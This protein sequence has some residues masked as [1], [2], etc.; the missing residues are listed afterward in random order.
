MTISFP[1]LKDINCCHDWD[2]NSSIYNVTPLF[3]SSLIFHQSPS[4]YD[5]QTFDH[6]GLLPIPGMYHPHS[7]LRAFA[8]SVLS[9]HFFLLPKLTQLIPTP[10]DFNSLITVLGI[11]SQ[12]QKPGSGPSF[13][14]YYS[15]LFLSFTQLTKIQY[16][17]QYLI[18][19][20]LSNYTVNYLRAETALAFPSPLQLQHL[21]QQLA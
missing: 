9:P 10:T 1:R 7:C 5:S 6:F 12:H 8:E 11:H 17:I 2:Q 13:R 19:L 21:A 3:F 16:S 20:C 4:C 18:H 15:L 14:H